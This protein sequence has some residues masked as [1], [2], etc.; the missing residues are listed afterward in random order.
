MKSLIS[1]NSEQMISKIKRG[2]VLVIKDSKYEDMCY[3]SN[4]QKQQF[5]WVKQSAF[6][7]VHFPHVCHMLWY[8]KIFCDWTFSKT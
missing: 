1:S 5:N 2:A 4:V 3:I 8:D 6:E 7:C